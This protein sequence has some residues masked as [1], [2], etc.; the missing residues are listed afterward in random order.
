ML[1]SVTHVRFAGGGMVLPVGDPYGRQF[2]VEHI[3]GCLRKNGGLEVE[4]RDERW[5][6]RPI[7]GYCARCGAPLRAG[8]CSTHRNREPWCIYCAFGTVSQGARQRRLQS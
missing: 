7:D 1:N 5:R 2:L 3:G 8:G 4:F 6:V